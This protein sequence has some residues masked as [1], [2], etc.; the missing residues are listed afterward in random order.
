VRGKSLKTKP[1][2]NTVVHHI[3]N[4]NDQYF[5]RMALDQAIQAF[6][7]GEV[8]VGAVLV[9]QGDVM[10]TGFNRREVDQDPTAHAE[11]MAIREASS[12]L[13]SWRL[14]NTTLY[15]TLEP[16]AMCAGALIQARISR[17]VFGAADPK[18]GACGSICDLLAEP[19]FNH[20][21]LVHSGILADECGTI[22]QMF[23]Q[24]LRQSPTV[25]SN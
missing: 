2:I 23:F 16:C 7:I 14:N 17:L 11:M 15:V 19:R 10:A 3:E 6:A 9:Q 8:P 4:P 21:V 1:V 25:N 22:L 12:K 24:H 13:G 18:A 20:R 5:M